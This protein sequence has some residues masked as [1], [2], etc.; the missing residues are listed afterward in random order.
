MKSP[1]LLTSAIA[2]AFLFQP[3]VKAEEPTD[4]IPGLR[5]LAEN[6][7]IAFNEKDAAAVA[8]LFSEEG[9]ISDLKAEN[10]ISGR[11]EIQAH[12]AERLA[13]ENAPKIAIEVESVRLLGPSLAVEDGTAHYTLPG[14]SEPASSTSYT[15]VLQK[16]AQGAWQIVSSRN[17]G[18]ATEAAGNLAELAASLKGDWTC[19][20]GD[21]RLDMAFGWDDSGNYLSGEMLA[22]RADAKPLHTTAR[23]GWDAARKVISCWTFDDEGGFAKADW[24]A[25]D[26]G[27]IVRTEGTTADG[28]AM[29]ANQ[30]LTFE[31]AD[32]FFWAGTDRLVNGEKLPDSKL[33]IV[34]QAPEP[35]LDAISET[36]TE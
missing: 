18:D 21:L 10:L 8:A 16:N 35:A 1:N 4:E 31:G 26:N 32:L 7:I 13:A 3:S 22:T 19:Q 24:T 14:E 11:V 17:L 2:I 28:E 20:S 5:Q 30:T 29:S 12:Y 15:A 6:F 33:R 27:W 36:V 23:F 9:E 34:R 25:S